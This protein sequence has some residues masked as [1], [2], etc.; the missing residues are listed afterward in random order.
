MNW[1]DSRVSALDSEMNSLCRRM[2]WFMS[3]TGSLHSESNR[4]HSGVSEL[5][6]E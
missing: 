2:N 4:F 6:S 3:N 1:F 5:Y